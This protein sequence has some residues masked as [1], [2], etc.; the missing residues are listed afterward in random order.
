MTTLH[1]T[2]WK[3]AQKD[4]PALYAVVKNLRSPLNQFKDALKHMLDQKSIRAFVK[5]RENLTMKNGFLYHKLQLKATGED[6]WCFVVPKTHRSVALDGCHHEAAH[7]GQCHSFSLM[8]E[9]FWWPG[10]AHELKNCVKNCARCKKLEGAP[11]IAKLKKLPCSSPGEILRIDYTSIEETVNLNEKPVIHNVLVMQDHFSKHVVAYV[12]KDQKAKTAAKALR[13]GYF[14]LFGAPAYLVSDQG[15]AFTGKVVESL[16]KLYRV[17]KLRTSSYHAQTNGQVERMNQTLIRMIGKLDEEKKAHWSEYLPELM[18]SYNSMRSAVTGYSPHF[19]L[20]GR[21]LRKPVDYQFFTIRDPPHKAKLEESVADLQKRLKEAFEMAR[22]LTSEEAVKQQCYYD[23]KAGAVALQPRDVVMVRTNRFV[24]KRKVKDQWEKGGFVVV[25][26][27]DDWLVYKFQ[28]PPTGNQCNPTYR[29]LHQNCLMLVPSEDDTA[30][31]TTQLL[32]SATIVLNACM[33]TLL[34]EV[35]DGDVA[36]EE[37]A[38]PESVTTSLLTHQ[39]SGPIPQVW[40]NGE[41]RTQ[42]YTQ[43]ESKA[44]ESQPELIEDD[45]SDTEPVSS[46]S[47]DEEA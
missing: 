8:Q 5:A 41:F 7:Q 2:N 25:K 26:Q 21:R 4:D 27:L 10:M 22:R 47:E 14:G 13:W 46:G 37:E 20:F 34:D 18:L 36:S 44:V 35:D 39:G 9:Q 40:L 23:C 45:V 43:M 31:D 33:G 30:S 42:P 16:A 15:G 28:C 1:V 32:A 11:P 19:L 24:G 17:Q 38:A 3:Q 6:V 29:I 12:V